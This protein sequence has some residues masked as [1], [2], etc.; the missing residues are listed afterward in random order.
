MKKLLSSLLLLIIIGGITSC[1]HELDSADD[2]NKRNHSEK[3]RPELKTLTMSFGGDFV[4]ESDE[5]LYRA[6]DG[7]T[8]VGI[9]VYRTEKDNQ[10]ATEEKYAYG[11]FIG[12]DNIKIDVIT[13]YTYRFEASILIER[14]DKLALNNRRY[15]EPFMLHDGLSTG[16]DNSW[17]FEPGD[18]D[19]FISVDDKN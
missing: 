13:G 6:G 17:G 4:S 18:L 1:R 12:K 8:F 5:P 19:D 11:L 15:N 3:E 7:E 14:D 16:F 2:G 10:Q 9:N